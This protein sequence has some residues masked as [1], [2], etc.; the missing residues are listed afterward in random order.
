MPTA[1]REIKEDNARTDRSRVLSFGKA[2]AVPRALRDADFLI[3]L[4]YRPVKR[5]GMAALPRIN[6]RRVND[7]HTE[8]L[9]ACEAYVAMCNV[10]MVRCPTNIRLTPW[11]SESAEMPRT[12]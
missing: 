6:C 8:G 3:F 9:E 11:F 2:R 10:T 5:R 4:W 7:H 12:A 1:R